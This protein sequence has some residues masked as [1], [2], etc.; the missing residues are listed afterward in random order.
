MP[1]TTDNTKERKHNSS[2]KGKEDWSATVKR[3]FH[4]SEQRLGTR[5]EE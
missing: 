5:R 1:G 4:R 2:R 3:D